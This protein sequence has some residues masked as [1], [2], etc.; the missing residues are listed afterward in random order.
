MVTQH[1]VRHPLLVL[2]RGVIAAQARGETGATPPPIGRSPPQACF[3]SLH[4]GSRLRGCIGTLRPSKQSLEE[5][6]AANALAAATRD[7]RFAPLGLDEL[8][9]I[10]VS[11]DVL[12]QL[13]PAGSERDLDPDQYGVVVR[14]GDRCGVL[15]PRLE[16]IRTPVQQIAIC[17]KKAGIPADSEV[18]LER[19]TVLRLE[20]A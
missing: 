17:R 8:P 11:I 9:Q 3:V 5:E 15:L 4:A 16:G 19:F 2:A 7:P 1:G 18:T 10:Q 20:E 6:V 14:Q 12:S 13:E